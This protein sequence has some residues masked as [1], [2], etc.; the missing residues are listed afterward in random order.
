[1]KARL[2]PARSQQR[3]RKVQA[4]RAVAAV[5]TEIGC[6]WA[7]AVSV[8]ASWDEAQAAQALLAAGR[9]RFAGLGR[10]T[11]ERFVSPVGLRAAANVLWGLAT[12][13]LPLVRRRESSRSNNA[14][15]LGRTPHLVFGDATLR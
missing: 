9:L 12:L 5:P 13:R 8:D 2:R 4:L 15:S 14:L 6:E 3:L 10:R 11:R 1:M 7:A